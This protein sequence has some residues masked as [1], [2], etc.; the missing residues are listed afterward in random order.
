M[1]DSTFPS[2]PEDV[3]Y[4]MQHSDDGCCVCIQPAGHSREFV[5]CS[6]HGS[7]MACTDDFPGRPEAIQ[8]IMRRL[9]DLTEGCL[10]EYFAEQI[11]TYAVQRAI[12][13]RYPK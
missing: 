2:Q 13:E 11:A 4:C 12:K 9:G 3:T 5:A 8:D 6:Q 7:H 1:S 10:D